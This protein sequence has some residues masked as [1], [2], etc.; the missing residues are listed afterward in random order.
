MPQFDLS[1]LEHYTKVVNSYAYLLNNFNLAVNEICDAAKKFAESKYAE[2]GH[3]SITVDFDSTKTHATIYAHGE[4]VAF[5]EFGIGEYAK[6]TYKGDLPTEGVPITGSW[7]YYYDSD[8][9]RSL[10]GLKGW[11]W[12]AVFVTGRKAEAEMWETSKFIREQSHK[13]IQKY[14]KTESG[15]Q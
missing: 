6:G 7:E 15:G 12:G 9:K 10:N 2:N 13:I 3:S 8:S 5:F 1:G 4:A 11:R 14:M